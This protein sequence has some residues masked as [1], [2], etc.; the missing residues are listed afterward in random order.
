MERIRVVA[1]IRPLIDN[2]IKKNETVAVEHLNN[3]NLKIQTEYAPSPKHY[4]FGR[5]F[6][7]NSSQEDI[8]G[9]LLPLL[10]D[11]LNG[12]NASCITYGQ[13]GT[14]KTHT[15][16]GLDLW[17]IENG[18]VP[19]SKF[20]FA[21]DLVNI[22]VIPRAM[23]WLFENVPESGFKMTVSY[24]EIYNEKLL[25][26]LVPEK[27]RPGLEIREDGQSKTVVS[28]ITQVHLQAK[29]QHHVYVLTSK[30]ILGMLHVSVE[31]ESYVVVVLLAYC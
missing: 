25:D 19:H 3:T 22:G 23:K 9:E 28:N 1:R 12:Y 17:N 7:A 27:N 16:L 2:E 20:H 21:T 31:W 18:S 24:M 14:G 26:L 10:S 8:F 6:S 15:M 13:T 30:G 4:S 29:L 11:C 5:V